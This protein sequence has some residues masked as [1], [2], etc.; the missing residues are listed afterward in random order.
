VATVGDCISNN[1]M[2][3]LYGIAKL[4]LQKP[5]NVANITEIA[6]QITP[7][8]HQRA[9]VSHFPPVWLE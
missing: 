9:L 5:A 6:H 7:F 4:W 1:T 2:Q 8:N 3:S